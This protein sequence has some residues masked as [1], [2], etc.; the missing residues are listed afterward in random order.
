MSKDNRREM[1]VTKNR[2]IN[3]EVENKRKTITTEEFKLKR[4]K[5]FIKF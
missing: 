2:N 1:I 5:G 4:G 3:N